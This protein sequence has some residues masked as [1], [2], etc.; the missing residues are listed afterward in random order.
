[1]VK[2]TGCIC[3]VIAAVW[4]RWLQLDAARR[5]RETLAGMIAA[6]GQIAEEIRMARTP[7]PALLACIG[8]SRSGGEGAFFRAV[9]AAL[10]AGIS[11]CDAWRGALDGLALPAE[12]LAVLRELANGLQGD[13]EKVCN[14]VSLATKKLEKQAER[15]EKQR[16][17]AE[18][19]ATA[20]WFSASALLV[21][22]LI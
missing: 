1:M 13:E 6:L 20:L 10:S 19:R 22:L 5:Q 2:L 8:R 14:A 21:I 16:P 3:V 9:S 17:E 4:A 11:L 18:R 7:M 12:S 15:A